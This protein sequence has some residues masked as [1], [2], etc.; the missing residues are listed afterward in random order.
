MLLNLDFFIE[1]ILTIHALALGVVFLKILIIAIAVLTLGY[2]PRTIF[3]TA[4]TLFQVGEFAFLLAS[5]G[6][7]YDLL[8][9]ETYQYFLAISISQWGQ[10]LL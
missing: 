5:V 7:E 8:A 6:M 10:L 2:P 1:N 4:L 3:I 9:E